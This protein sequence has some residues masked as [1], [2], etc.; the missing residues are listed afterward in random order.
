[1]VT[2][3]LEYK[4]VI[5]YKSRYPLYQDP[6]I[7]IYIYMPTK[8]E[9]RIL[10]IF[11]YNVYYLATTKVKIYKSSKFLSFAVCSSYL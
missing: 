1:M 5:V 9:S 6:F 2:D 7:Y 10:I 3:L 11:R 4:T 8:H